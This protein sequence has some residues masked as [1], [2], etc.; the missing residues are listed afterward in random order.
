LA[1]SIGS[2]RHRIL[3]LI[4]SKDRALQLDA[5]LRSLLRRAR[6]AGT[7]DLKVL[8]RATSSDHLRQYEMLRFDYRGVAF[9]RE[10][11][12]RSQ[13]PQL[14]TG[15]EKVLFLVDDN[16]FVR[17]FTFAS[18]AA[19]LDANPDTIGVSLRLGRNT[20]YCYSLDRP[21]S[22]PN[23]ADEGELLRFRWVGAEHDFG[24]PL[25]VSSSLYRV[26]DIL[27]LL[28]ESWFINP[29]TLEHR[30]AERAVK[31]ADRFPNLLCFPTSVTFC[32]PLNRVQAAYSNRCA[33]DPGLRA[34]DL[35][36]CFDDGWRMDVDQLNGF[37]PQAC[38][39]EIRIPLISRH[40]DPA[41]GQPRTR[42][43]QTL[44]SSSGSDEGRP[45]ADVSVIIPCFNQGR[46][47][48]DCL[49]SLVAQSVLPREVIVVN[50]GSTEA[51]TNDLCARLPNY[52]FPFTLHVLRKPNGGLPS[53]RNHGIRFCRGDIVLP[54]DADDKLLPHAIETYVK[55]FERCPD[56]DVFYPDLQHFG[57]DDSSTVQP[58]FNRWRQTVQNLMVCS[59]AIRRKV[60]RE[61]HWYDE[62]MRRG[63]EDWEFWIR[64]CCLG[65]FTAAPL[66]KAVFGY[67][68]WGYSMVAAV[69][70]EQLMAQIRSLHTRQGIWSSEIERRLRTTDAPTHCLVCSDSRLY[71]DADDL[72]AIPEKDT[73]TFLNS[74]YVSRFLWFGTFAPEATAYLQLIVN[75]LARRTPAA[76]YAF[77]DVASGKIYLVVF[78][79]LLTIRQSAKE[80]TTARVFG[81]AVLVETE[82]ERQP[83]LR[84]TSYS[85]TADLPLDDAMGGCAPLRQ[86]DLLPQRGLE[87]ARIA[88]DLHY[89]FHREPM[90]PLPFAP[91][92]GR[93]TLVIALPYLTDGGSE[94]AV[95]ILL[96]EG[97]LRR[98]FERIL[99]L[100]FLPDRH[101]A[102]SSFEP[103][104]DGIYHLGN[105]Y[106][107]EEQ[108]LQ[109][110][111]R[112]LEHVAASDFLVA[113]SAHGYKLIPRIRQAGLP[114]RVSAQ[115]H[116]LGLHPFTGLP[117][118]GYPQEV[119][120]KYAALVDRV[121]CVSD[122]LTSFLVDHLY[123]PADKVR[124]IRLGVDQK[125]F[126]P[127]PDGGPDHPR[128]VVWCGRLSWEKDPLLALRVAQQCH[129]WSP[130]VHFQFVG[131][132]PERDSFAEQLRAYQ[133]Q[134][135]RVDWAPHTDRF[136]EI[137]RES[138]CL[139]LTSHYE[140]IP[141][142][143]MEA[144]S[145][146]LPVVMPFANTAVAE[147]ADFGRY[148]EITDRTD[149][150]EYSRQI[151]E[152]IV[153]KRCRPH[154]VLSH[155][156]YARE[157]IDWL[158]PSDAQARNDYLT[159]V[160]GT[161]HAA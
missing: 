26:G 110:A 16:L 46:F 8:Y 157:M 19:A 145:A 55:A 138:D 101:P 91:G 88:N 122:K 45:T 39:Q 66:G 128:Q 30:L 36:L 2:V 72:V 100:T 161:G 47:L 147:I 105:V 49:E 109:T 108:M 83:R 69:N 9:V 120:R 41:P 90:V 107:D 129:R 111:L 127:A 113:N 60:F 48:T 133:A 143:A 148:Y 56:V 146:G 140:G 27:P 14:V 112:L 73:A 51:Q 124:T 24:Y 136:E 159:S 137:L 43:T 86:C 10:A 153:G 5:T 119:A 118:E 123:F 142:V 81:Q 98:H 1:T 77:R 61:G 121:T 158:F 102:H 130:D 150:E 18:A 35:R 54:L 151:H 134:G 135:G 117:T 17:D 84:S 65:P 40:R 7:V 97:S 21:Q 80:T 74:D 139:F 58:H 34:E 79:R 103:L 141:L 29:N 15:Y 106:T 82:G 144:F 67:R 125:R 99:I 50:D 87:D 132:G 52:R 64:T 28:Q 57:N 53:A 152:A 63:Y 78:D 155:H 31:Q 154:E 3:G 6:D 44:T 12:F 160:F 75:E 38:H 94:F 70:H 32:V 95:S 96:K 115:L 131:D 71:A 104:C 149:I 59:S 76:A 37:V 4:F 89:Y 23:F 114:V 25:E 156:R 116:S 13:V 33:A 68:K 126:R 22:L 85:K 62:Q 92:K 42:G 11:V 93:R 20:T